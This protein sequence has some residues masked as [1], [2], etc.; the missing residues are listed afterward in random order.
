M[1]V[2]LNFQDL[3]SVFDDLLKQTLG[4]LNGELKWRTYE[5]A[6]SCARFKAFHLLSDLLLHLLSN[7]SPYDVMQLGFYFFADC[8]LY[9]GLKFVTQ[10]LNLN[11]L[12]C[13]LIIQSFANLT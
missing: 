3:P 9:F 8:F 11:F 1:K 4:Y 10:N 6:E 7:G 5:I 2:S 12:P 13:D